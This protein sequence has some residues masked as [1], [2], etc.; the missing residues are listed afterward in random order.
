MKKTVSRYIMFKL[1]K[2][3]NKEKNLEIRQRK[4]EI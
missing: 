4:K 1:L 2:V 3:D